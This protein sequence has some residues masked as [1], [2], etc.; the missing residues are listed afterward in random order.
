MTQTDEILNSD[1]PLVIGSAADSDLLGR[2]AFSDRVSRTLTSMSTQ[3]GVVVS[4]EGQWGSG[5]TSCISLIEENIGKQNQDLRVTKFNPW[6][7]S[8]QKSLITKLI[9]QIADTIGSSS[10]GRNVKK[11][12]KAASELRAYSHLF[13]L[14]K[15]LP[16]SEPYATITKSLFEGSGAALEKIAKIKT[17]SLSQKKEQLEQTLAELKIPVIVIIDDVDRL[18]PSEIYE[19]IRILKIVANLPYVTY[20]VSWDSKYIELSLKKEGVPFPSKYLDKIVQIRLPIP[21]M[22]YSSKWRLFEREIAPLQRDKR[23]TDSYSTDEINSAKRDYLSEFHDLIDTPRDIVRLANTF[24]IHSQQLWGEIDLFDLFGMSSFIANCPEIYQLIGRSP[25]DFAPAPTIQIND[26]SS[27]ENNSNKI[28]E[29]LSD[30]EV[31][32]AFSDLLG[33]LFPATGLNDR[34]HR[35]EKRNRIANPERLEVFLQQQAGDDHVRFKDVRSYYE[36]EY[37]R[38]TITNELTNLNYVDFFDAV[39]TNNKQNITDAGASK[40]FVIAS[41]TFLDLP[42]IVELEN[43]EPAKMSPG[44]SASFIAAGSI[45]EVLRSI[46]SDAQKE[47]FKEIVVN[48]STCSMGARFMLQYAAGTTK[49]QFELDS[50]ELKVLTEKLLENLILR[51]KNKTVGNLGGALRW[52]AEQKEDSVAKIRAVLEANQ[53][54]YRVALEAVLLTQVDS[55]KGAII[56]YS[57]NLNQ[58][59]AIFGI[60]RLKGLATKELSDSPDDIIWSCI[61]EES[62]VYLVD[63]SSTELN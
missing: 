63:G 58:L 36:D 39:V 2:A 37:S 8:D 41:A 26:D 9:G 6:M 56:S 59:E 4:I 45:M 35:Y 61:E 55:F 17:P 28:S 53:E 25:A 47:I 38:E 13:D 52:V 21:R 48:P 12:E 34:L 32:T 14:L 62:T 49:L 23:F 16:G 54:L 44:L 10:D 42:K 20:L 50:G 30:S 22:N 27:T 11:V 60:A 18:Y 29:A 3:T 31:S 51:I 15:L 57:S 7:V 33:T 46:E 24:K 5:K 40:K 1:E 43:S 19:I